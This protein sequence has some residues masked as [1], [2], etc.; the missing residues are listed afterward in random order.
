VICE[1]VLIHIQDTALNSENQ[2]DQEKID[3]VGRMGGDFY[4]RAHGSALFRLSMPGRNLPVGYESLPRP[5]RESLLL[6]GNQLAKLVSVPVVPDR[7]PVLLE[8]WLKENV[9]DRSTLNHPGR[10]DQILSD[11]LDKNYVAIAWQVVL[12]A[13]SE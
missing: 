5:V 13:S 6:T 9:Y 12:A 1:V 2:I 10:V 8:N 7:D 3:L 4:S 11:L